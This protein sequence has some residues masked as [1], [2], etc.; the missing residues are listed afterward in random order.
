LSL[1]R[2]VANYLS[3]EFNGEFYDKENAFFVEDLLTCT[4]TAH[5]DDVIGRIG[6]ILDESTAPEG[7]HQAVVSNV[8][9]LIVRVIDRFSSGKFADA[10]DKMDKI[11]ES[12]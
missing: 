8:T 7:Y 4:G 10:S 12:V 1:R 5:A 9:A 11:I 3:E 6:E 2:E